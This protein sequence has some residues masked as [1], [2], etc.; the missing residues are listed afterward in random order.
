MVEESAAERSCIDSLKFLEE[1]M[2]EESAAEVGA[3]ESVVAEASNGVPGEEC[4][5]GR[6]CSTSVRVL[7]S[8]TYRTLFNMF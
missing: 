7:C 6:N 1:F 4:F 8:F 3:T 5:N 2:V